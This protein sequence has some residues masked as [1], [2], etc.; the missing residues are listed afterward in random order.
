MNV[1]EIQGVSKD[2]PGVKA[3]D[4]VDFSVCKGEI[5]ALLGE[6][7]AG[8]ST[9]M[10]ILYGMHKPDTGI[11]AI[12]GKNIDISSPMEAIRLGIGMVHQHFM[13]VP[14]LTV[15]ENIVVGAEP[16]R[17]LFFDLQKSI[18]EVDKM[19]KK[20][21]FTIDPKKKVEELSVG[22]RQRIEILKALYRGAE[23]LILDEPTAVLTPLEVKELFLTLR[24][25]KEKGKSIILITHKLHE[26]MEISDKVTV[27][28]DGKMIGTVFPKDTSANELANMMVGREVK[29]GIK[30]RATNIGDNLFEIKH[31]SLKNGDRVCLKDINLNL[32]KGEILGI[33]GVEGNGQ[34]EL[35]EVLTGLRRP[36]EMS[37]KINGH[38]LNGNANDFIRAGVGHIPEDRGDRGLV[39][40]MSI[41]KNSILGYHRMPRFVKKGMFQSNLV[42]QYVEVLMKTFRIKA[43]NAETHVGTLSGGNQQKVIIGRVFSQNTQ[44]VIAAQPTRGVD[45]GAIEYIHEKMLEFRNQGKAILLISADLDEVKSLSDR[46]A[47]LYKGCV[48]AQGI[49]EDFTDTELGVLMTGGNICGKEKQGR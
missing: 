1:V 25:L 36:D 24:Q 12:N 15:A 49:T 29:L 9:L 7:G 4:A 17:G 3:L 38:E 41:S 8:K 13:L 31:L 34:T 16:K 33:A 19:A 22:E 30:C 5:H 42:S 48:V 28:R 43:A 47:V 39:M 45:V 35:I 6:N 37:L 27:M 32:R 26:I 23:I 40:G 21:G 2:F 11:I 20:F 46:I 10:K 18:S 14:V 44:V